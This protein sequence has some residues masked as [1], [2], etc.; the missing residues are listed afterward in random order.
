MSQDAPSSGLPHMTVAELAGLQGRAD[1]P[2][3][4]DVR[5]EPE[6]ALC[7]IAG[8]VHIPLAQLPLRHGELPCDRPVVVYCHHGGRS[9]RAAQW[10]LQ[11][12]HEQVV[13]LT[14]GIDAWAIQVDQTMQRY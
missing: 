10:L 9:A 11:N 13:N 14:G 8:A 12:G 5:E 1:A 2:L 7:R 6:V 3:L 4:L